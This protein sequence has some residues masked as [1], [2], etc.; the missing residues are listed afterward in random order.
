MSR[1]IVRIPTPLRPYT[2]GA[3]EVEVDADTVGEALAALGQ[4]HS[5]L[6]PRVCSADG[7]LRPFV[8]LYLGA[9]NVRDLGGLAAAL[10]ASGGVLAIVPAV[11]GG[12]GGAK[13]IREQ[14]LA[15]L[16]ASV[17]E[18]GPREAYARQ[19]AGAALIDVREPE[20]IAQ[21]SPPGAYRLGRGFL[22]LRIADSIADPQR[23]LL[24]LCGG[25][26]RSLFAAE[27]L[28]RLG[29]HDVASVA[30]G[31]TRWKAEGLPF[32]T[33]RGLDAHAR[34]R[35]ARHL[36]MPEVGEAGQQRLLASRVLLIGAG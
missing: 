26:A 25:G 10:P 22:E 20:E 6:L 2:G 34:E 9:D 7:S 27:G 35:Y 16:K 21:G 32:E 15:E 1:V 11:A 29:Y 14:R 36:A 3:D 13:G 18:I 23:P 28:Q 24:V 31:F 8:N 5:G 17:P 12:A 4:R 33:P 30:G 19:L